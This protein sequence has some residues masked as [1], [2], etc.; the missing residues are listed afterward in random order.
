MVARTNLLEMSAEAEAAGE[1]SSYPRII[2][3]GGLLFFIT[4]AQKGHMLVFNVEHCARISHRGPVKN[5]P[6]IQAGPRSHHVAWPSSPI[7]V[8]FMKPCELT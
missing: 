7:I 4:Q 6:P 8:P 2:R 5:L 3:M 1:K